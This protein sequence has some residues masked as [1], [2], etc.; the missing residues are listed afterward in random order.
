[1][2]MKWRMFFRF[3][4]GDSFSRGIMIQIMISMHG[5][6]PLSVLNIKALSF[7]ATA[8]NAMADLRQQQCRDEVEP[9]RPAEVPLGDLVGL[10]DELPPSRTC[11]TTAR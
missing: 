5:S 8:I 1:M 2:L 7:L 10:D 9:E 3:A 11:A 6:K 4:V